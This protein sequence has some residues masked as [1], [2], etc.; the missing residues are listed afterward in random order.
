[1]KVGIYKTTTTV[2]SPVSIP[3]SNPA[4]KFGDVFKV[5]K[6]FLENGTNEAEVIQPEEDEPQNKFSIQDYDGLTLNLKWGLYSPRKQ[7]VIND[8]QTII[9]NPFVESFTV[10][11]KRCSL[12][13]VENPNKNIGTVVQTFSG[14]KANSLKIDLEKDIDRYL[15]LDIKVTD[16]FDNVHTGHLIVSNYPAQ[17]KINNIY[18]ASGFAYIEY[19]GTNDLLGVN[20]YGFTGTNIYGRLTD[21]SEFREGNKVKTLNENNSGRIPL[22]PK[23]RFHLMACPYDSAGES[24]AISLVDGVSPEAPSGFFFVPTYNGLDQNKLLGGRDYEIKVNYDWVQNPFVDI[25]YSVFDT[26]SISSPVSGYEGAIALDQG[27]LADAISS[28]VEDETKFLFNNTM[29][30]QRDTETGTMIED[31]GEVYGTGAGSKWYDGC[32]RYSGENGIYKYAYIDTS[33]CQI[34]CVTMQE[35]ESGLCPVEGVFSMPI[36]DPNSDEIIFQSGPNFSQKYEKASTYLR[37]VNQMPAVILT[38]AQLNKIKEF[39]S[40]KGWI[41]LRRKDVGCL[42]KLFSTKVQ[43]DI[44][45]DEIDFDAE[46]APSGYLDKDGD[47]RFFLSNDVGENWAWVNSS[48]DHIY[49]YA[50]SSGYYNQEGQV[51]MQLEYVDDLGQHISRDTQRLTF[52]RPNLINIQRS[53]GD[54][55][56]ITVVYDIENTT[57]SGNIAH[58]EVTKIAVHTG[59]NPDYEVSD[60][61][62]FTE[63]VPT[64]LNGGVEALQTT[65]TILPDNEQLQNIK[66]LPYDYLGPGSVF[67]FTEEF[68]DVPMYKGSQII[69]YSLD[70][71]YNSSSTTVDI[72]FPM[73]TQDPKI[74]FGISTKNTIDPPAFINAMMVGQAEEQSASFVLSQ[75]PPAT[76]YFI[77]LNVLGGN[78][79][80]D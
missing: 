61:N 76:G 5:D 51:N 48:G 6:P 32:P 11:K 27:L 35:I 77:T 20:L 54:G 72:N 55:D 29:E 67:S 41:G 53:E 33:T 15:N 8:T 74:T 66:L 63:L 45:F 80:D 46:G 19:T 60:L 40:V 42:E 25:K 3:L 68:G 59:S 22:Y 36:D 49:K 23:R 7:N 14:L 64:E 50:G 34:K 38:K 24:N 12:E 2:S 18:T 75:P 62:L 16:N 30:W 47:Q 56:S 9:E 79:A 71:N 13:E 52:Q 70:E 57:Y 31:S 43:N 58:P 78:D 17:A 73:P 39:E 65:I 26:G 1:M 10:S 44:F 69:E 28:D 21:S 4:D 37:E